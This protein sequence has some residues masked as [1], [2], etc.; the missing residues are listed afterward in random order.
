M[1]CDKAVHAILKGFQCVAIHKVGSVCLFV[2]LRGTAQACFNANVTEKSKDV[3]PCSIRCAEEADI[4]VTEIVHVVMHQGR[5][6]LVLF[7]VQSPLH[8]PF[9]PP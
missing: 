9:H 4:R 2:I 1:A 5:E 7:R 8:S 6:G 3:L